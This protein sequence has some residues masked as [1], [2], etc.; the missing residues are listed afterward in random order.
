VGR[1]VFINDPSR[2]KVYALVW[3]HPSFR[4]LLLDRTGALQSKT[5]EYFASDKKL[6]KESRDVLA[7]FFV[8]MGQLGAIRMG[9][10]PAW[11]VS[12]TMSF[13]STVEV[14]RTKYT[15]E[16]EL[17]S[18][19]SLRGRATR[20]WLV[21]RSADKR[22]ILKDC[23]R[24]S[25]RR[26]EAEWYKELQDVVCANLPTVEWAGRVLIENQED[27]THLGRQG[28]GL[29]DAHGNVLAN[30]QIRVHERIL[31]ACQGQSLSAVRD[32]ASFFTAMVGA[33]QGE[34]ILYLLATFHR[35]NPHGRAS[36]A[37]RS[38]C[39]APRHQPEQHLIPQQQRDPH[40]SGPSGARQ[41][42]RDRRLSE[43]YCA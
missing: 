38:R 34:D 18:R 31:F 1:Q 39:A 16:R 8:S 32:T 14:D 19:S 30:V 40:R 36:G 11:T 15:V 29:T 17:F 41:S 5:Y 6:R 26:S 2:R 7:R 21:K 3:C 13:D 22:F 20:V 23:W 43:P 33:V 25:T 4:F 10:D 42:P 9:Y 37:I 12:R 24:D 35:L 27:T 28:C